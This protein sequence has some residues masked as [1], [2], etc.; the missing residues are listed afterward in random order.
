MHPVATTDDGSV[1]GNDALITLLATRSKSFSTSSLAE[2]GSL[3]KQCLD[4]LRSDGWSTAGN[5]VSE[6]S[7][8]DKLPPASDPETKNLG[9]AMRFI[10]GSAVKSWLDTFVAAAA[11]ATTTTTTIT[12][13][14]TALHSTTRQEGQFTVHGPV[15]VGMSAPG[16]SFELYADAQEQGR[17]AAEASFGDPRPAGRRGCAAHGP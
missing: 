11:A 10:F 15:V 12:T 6:A 9:A 7:K 8:V 3:A 2:R 1:L 4:A 14:T 17:E 16:I 13:T 5:W